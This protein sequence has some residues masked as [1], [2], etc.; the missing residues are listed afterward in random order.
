MRTHL[1]SLFNKL[2]MDKSFCP[3]IKPGMKKQIFRPNKQEHGIDKKTYK[4]AKPDIEHIED[5][6]IDTHDLTSDSSENEDDKEQAFKSIHQ[7]KQEFNRQNI[8]EDLQA[9]Y[10]DLDKGDFQ[11]HQVSKEDK[12]QK[13]FDAKIGDLLSS[14]KKRREQMSGK[15]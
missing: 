1:W 8:K 5:D 9:G 13:Q 4:V 6:N 12:K 10:G 14:F 11:K 15:K 3:D 7:E 2:A